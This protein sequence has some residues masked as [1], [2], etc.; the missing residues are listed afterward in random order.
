MNNATLLYRISYNNNY[1]DLRLE[2]RSLFLID[3]ITSSFKNDEDFINHYYNKMEINKFIRNH[4][5]IKGNLLIDYRNDINDKRELLPIYNQENIIY[6][7]DSYNNK[8][9]ELEKARKLLFNSK[10]QM[11]TKLVLQS[12]IFEKELNRFVTLD[13]DE[14]KYAKANNVEISL[15]NHRYYISFKSLL[16]HRINSVKLGILRNAYQDMLDIL[17]EKITS[18]NSNTLY[19]YNREARLLMK[20]YYSLTSEIS[21]S[22]LKVRKMFNKKYIL[23]KEGRV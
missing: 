2:N 11:F 18:K 10:N 17:K 4:N 22:N 20:K 15:I 7:D 3:R 5:N 21:I 6:K 12:K 8:L 9:S 14:E 23:C 13:N 19:F 16:N 1:D